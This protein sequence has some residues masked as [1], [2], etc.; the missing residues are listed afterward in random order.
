MSTVRCQ[1][2]A[3]S[4]PEGNRFCE[5]CGTELVA[6]CA[7]CG[8][9][10]SPSARFC[11]GC[12]TARAQG[13]A[14]ER[15]QHGQRAGWGELKQA[16]VLFAD[17]V[18]STEHIATMGPEEA[19]EQLKPAVAQ[20]CDAVQAFGG[21][22]MR[23]LGDGVMA[24]FGVPRALEEH[25]LLACQ[26]A[27]AMQQAFQGNEWGLAIRVGLHSGLV[28]SDPT[29][30]DVTRG[31]GAHGLVI[32]VASRVIGQAEPGGVCLTG[33]C[34]DLMRGAADARKL[35]PRMLK[36]LRDPVDIYVLEGVDQAVAAHT[37][38]RKILSPFCGRDAEMAILERA[39]RLTRDGEAQVVGVS[40]APGSGKSRLC[41]EFAQ[42][43]RSRGIPVFQVRAQPYG[44]ATPLQPILDILR[45][46]LFK[47]PLN[48][49][50][51]AARVQINL[52][53]AELGKPSAAD[54]NLLYE[55]LG[56]SE[57]GSSS[58][59][60][61]TD[62][63]VRRT[64]LLAIFAALIRKSATVDAVIVLE[65]MHWLD[66]ASE[67][68]VL[69][70]LNALKATKTFVLLNY[71]PRAPAGWEGLSN[72]RAVALR[73]L[74]AQDTEQ[75]VR[76]LISER[77][78]FT[79][80][81]ELVAQRSAGNPFF[82]EELVR[83][84]AQGSAFWP[85]GEAEPR[86]DTIGNSLPETVQ[87][88]IAARID[89][90]KSEQKGLLQICAILGKEGPLEILEKVAQDEVDHV[91]TSLATLC[92]LEFL[93]I[94]PDLANQFSFGHPLIQEVAYGMQLKATRS[95]IH[96][97]VGQAMETHYK[98]RIDEYSGL[99]GHHYEAA[100]K[101]LPAARHIARAARWL[102]ST[103][104]ASATRQWHRVRAVLKQ[105]PRDPEVDQLRMMA[106]G[107][108]AMLGWREGRTLAEV[109]PFIDEAKTLATEVDSKLTQMLLMVE[110]RMLQAT[111]ASAD[112]YVQRAQ[113][114]LA[115]VAPED[116]GRR[117][118]VNAV[119]SQAYGRAG[120]I[121][122]AMAANEAAWTDVSLIDPFDREFV[123]FV[124]EHWILAMRGR[125]LARSGKLD[126]A[127]AAWQRMLR[128]GA[129]SIDPTVEAIAHLGYV[130]F[131]WC[132]DDA[133]LARAQAERMAE[134]AA[135]RQVPYLKV[136]ALLCTGVAAAIAGDL[137]V[138]LPA[139]TAALALVRANRL[140]IEFE[141]EIL[142]AI[143]E[144]RLRNGEFEDAHEQVGQAVELARLRGARLAECRALIIQGALFGRGG[145]AHAE[146]FERAEKLIEQT[147]AT[148]YT[149]PLQRARR[150]L[151]AAGGALKTA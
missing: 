127:T 4:N 16:T 131:A 73:E 10:G 97:L 24:L 43:C 33:Q 124:V 18:S 140:A 12:G 146:C 62:P 87:A 81:C 51:H 1:S 129:G 27:L 119:L 44:H 150:K 143:A 67:E 71:R 75:L 109:Q 21:T 85:D 144:C 52:E 74:S 58:G 22:V 60:P 117:A 133:D 41:H 88:V 113:Q 94:L 42:A 38:Q 90:L 101:M 46:Y 9:A 123:G 7:S 145:G 23:T 40:G 11:G 108:I 19:M 57:R 48:C 120:L 147:G 56:V 148:A 107:Q 84:I 105:Q 29:S 149:A 141:S 79:R 142:A 126:E 134:L 103:D 116:V 70:L 54:Q 37:L 99:I 17:I 96:A 118:M 32:H 66:E 132:H 64:R 68:F 83:S 112:E 3:A 6:I 49:P 137:E 135:K 59:G 26:A 91:A 72:F 102:S 31:G 98:N 77:T 82:A 114:A 30:H 138:A 63:R 36:G 122:E 111:G 78:D 34:L 39:L 13:D 76:A 95:R 69:A 61:G 125:S 93:Q 20:M 47:I 35:G 151:P 45:A 121:G 50:S 80:I 106:S 89:R 92:R 115:L 55:F 104:T 53:L 65:D 130:E 8:V 86:L 128:D 100:G 28:A 110:G 136:V 14:V 5:T 139:L 15:S 2:C 25:A